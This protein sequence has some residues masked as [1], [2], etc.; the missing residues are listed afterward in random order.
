MSP[1]TE[2]RPG[3]GGTEDRPG[4]LGA[5]PEQPMIKTGEKENVD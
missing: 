4:G 5:S 1:G 2:A 3:G